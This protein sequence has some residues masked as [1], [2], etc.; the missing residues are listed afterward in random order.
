PAEQIRAALT[1]VT[2]LNEAV[3]A[4]PD[5][6]SWSGYVA[7]VEA[8]FDRFLDP[9]AGEA[10][11]G[12]KG[13]PDSLRQT[14]HDSLGELREMACLEPEVALVD[15]VA[16]FRRLMEAA[17]V[18]IGARDGSRG[19]GV[20]VLDAMAARGIPFR[21]LFVLGL[22]E[23]VFPRHVQEDAFL[24]DASRRLLEADLG[25]KIQE[26]LAGFDEEKLLYRLLCEAPREHLTLLYQRTDG[27]GRTLV[28]SSYLGEA[29][30]GALGAELTVP[31]RLTS[32]FKEGLAYRAE[33]LTPV[34]TGIKC[35]LDRIVPRR[36]LEALHPAGGLVKQGL[37]AL[38]EQEAVASKL[39]AYDGLTGPLASFWL[40]LKKRGFS[41]TALQDYAT[42]PFRYFA[43]QVLH[44]ESLVVPEAEDQ[45]GP[46]ELGVLAH[47]ILRRCYQKLREEGYFAGP[48]GSSVEPLAVLEETAYQ[49]FGRFALTHPVGFPIVW[50]LH[51][52]R[53]LR[54]LRDVLREDLAE[55]S[56]EGW[57]PILF[58]E[59][60]RGALEVGADEAREPEPISLSGRLDRVD[61]SASR[62]AYRIVDYKFKA[63]REPD[64]LDKNLPLGAVRGLRLQPP[65]Y[66]AMAASEMSWRLTQAGASLGRGEAARAEGVWFYYLAQRWE[67][68]NGQALTRAEFPGHAWTSGLR[69]PLER[70]IRYVLG[71]IK[72]GRFFIYPEGYCEHCDYR[73]TCRVTHQPTSWRARSDHATVKPHRD[74]RRAKPADAPTEAQAGDKVPSGRRPRRSKAQSGPAGRND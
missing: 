39:G 27:A 58:E 66:L 69:G 54:F 64:T 37:L 67:A 11:Q 28:P 43:G 50:E 17:T 70:V 63:S 24:R 74:I 16:A 34:E 7:L 29:R 61:W 3:G 71:G 62:K 52:E 48:P 5:T 41:P 44:L 9:L 51:Q 73:L 46:V 22:N 32:K 26:K 10:A 55:L 15:F 45:I 40:G 36:L 14:F 23:K 19:A 31:R 18:P 42:C 56:A 25:F 20:Q 68:R 1:V 53:L 35:L 57:E 65:L 30:E 47:G 8:L 33:R 72:A 12:D 21:A 60:M 2:A 59:S 13:Q 49:V 6:A 38:R 4:L